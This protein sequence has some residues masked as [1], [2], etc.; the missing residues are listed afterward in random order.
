MTMSDTSSTRRLLSIDALRG[1]DMFW[2]T[3]GSWLCCELCRLAGGSTAEK[4][5]AQMRHVEWTGL[6]FIDFVFPVFV[7]IAGLSYPFSHAKQVARGDSRGTMVRK[8]LR[9]MFLLLVLGLVYNGFLSADWHKLADFRYFSVLGKIGIAWGVAAFVYMLTSLRV[10]LA[11]CFAGFAAYAAL[12]FVVAPDAPAGASSTSLAGCFVGYLD[13]LFTPGHLYCGNLLEPSGPFV[14]FFGCSTALLGMCGGDLVRS[15]RWTP[16]RKSLLLALCGIGCLAAGFALSPI[17][18]IVKKL[19]TPSFALIASGAGFLAFALFHQ[20]IDVCGWTRWS[21]IFRL[22]GL[23]AIAIYFAGVFI[24]F[25]A[26]SKFFTGGVASLAGAGASLVIGLGAI[27]IRW[28]ALYFL[29]RHNI[30][31]KV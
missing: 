6:H 20:L 29:Y 30:F 11:V 23:N 25:G 7:F 28:L 26:I 21:F 12:L 10:R 13:R 1:F 22:I 14:S 4:L 3:G 8:I 18:P 27:G 17:C 16:A 5:S 24:N 15:S 2:I 31:F 9:R 19:W